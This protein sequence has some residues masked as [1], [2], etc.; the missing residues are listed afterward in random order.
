[1]ATLFSENQVNFARKTY[2]GKFYFVSKNLNIFMKVINKFLIYLLNFKVFLINLKRYFLRNFIKKSFLNKDDTIDIILSIKNTEIKKFSKKLKD[3]KYVFVENFIDDKSYNLILNKWP[4]INFFK[5]QNKIIKYYSTGF[6]FIDGKF[7]ESDQK[8]FKELE[9]LYY[10]I[11]S[12][13]FNSF[14]NNLLEFENLKFRNCTIKSSMAGNNSYLA[15]HIDGYIENT[16]NFIYFVDGNDDDLN[17]SGATGIYED[18]NF[19][20][21]IFIPTTLK[22][23]LLIYKTT[24]QFYHGFKLTKLPKNFYRKTVNFEFRA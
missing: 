20:K 16:Y 14:V 24:E 7:L 22:N 18:N 3:E 8:K 13:S 10:F 21:P 1:M 23:S 19:Q 5:Q 9:K 17:F 12:S 15:P 2:Y 4:D 6:W 11:N